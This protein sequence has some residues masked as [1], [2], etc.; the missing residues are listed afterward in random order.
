MD[1]GLIGYAL[2]DGTVATIIS[3]AFTPIPAHVVFSGP[4]VCRLWDDSVGSFPTPDVKAY[5]DYANGDA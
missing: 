3:G 1:P 4:Q 2:S 5:R